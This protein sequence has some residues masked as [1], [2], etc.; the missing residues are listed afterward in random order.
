M[1]VAPLTPD[2]RAALLPALAGWEPAAGRDAIAKRFVFADFIAAF[3]FMARVALAAEKADHHPEWSNI[4]NVVDVVLTTHDAGGISH[5][6]VA[7]ARTLDL[8][9]ATG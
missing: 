2:E 1:T 7:M 6:D 9:A 8:L 4:Y 3:G 5:R